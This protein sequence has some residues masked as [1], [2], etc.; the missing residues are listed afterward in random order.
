MAAEERIEIN[1]K[2]KS[3]INSPQRMLIGGKW[4]GAVSGKTFNSINP[5]TGEVITVVPEAQKEDI[6]LAVKAARTAFENPSWSGMTAMDR[7][8]L[9]FRLAD[10]IE[11]DAENLA[12]LE[13]LDNGK[14]VHMK[15]VREEI[16]GPVLTVMPWDDMDDL[17]AKANDSIYGLAAGIWTSNLKQAHIAARG[18]KAGTIWINCFNLV[19]P[20]SPFGGWKQ[21]GWGREHGRQAMELYSEVK[22]VWVNLS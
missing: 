15:I 22:S 6:D 14:P 8:K 12:V 18:V 5:A 10:L 16:F 4:V 19:D 21:S 9:L 1:E 17:I 11:R 20:A 13:C 2:V 7:T 3:I